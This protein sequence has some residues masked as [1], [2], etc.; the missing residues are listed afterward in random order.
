MNIL[1]AV[2]AMVY[3]AIGVTTVLAPLVSTVFF[4]LFGFAIYKA[5][6]FK[7]PTLVR[8]KRSYSK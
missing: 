7:A 3:A 1:F 6:T 5:L 2:L 8:S 4:C